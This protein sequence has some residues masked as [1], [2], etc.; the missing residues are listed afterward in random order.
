VFEAGA[1][2]FVSLPE[3]SDNVLFA[4]QKALARKRGAAVASGIASAPMIVIVGPKGG[5]GKTLTAVNLA[6]AL[7]AK[8]KRVAVVDLDLQFGDV[9][10]SYGLPPEKTIYDLAKSGGSLDTEKI[11][12]YLMKHRTGV[13]V[14][15]A[16]T[17]P[18]QASVVSIEFLREVYATLR[19]SNDF[20]I[21]DTPPGFTPEV[22]ATIDASSHV[23]MVAMLDALSL[24]N[25]KVGLETLELMGY[26][27]DRI[28]VVL[29]RADSRVGIT[30]TEV[31]DILG[32]VPDI[33]VPSSRNVPRAVNEGS[34][35][36]VADPKSAAARAFRSL[37][38][39]YIGDSRA[40][41]GE[42]GGP[43]RRRLSLRRSRS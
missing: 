12:A 25:T 19:S 36:T 6:A 29:N 8:Q 9:G 28:R 4:L 16:P 13:S 32:R 3:S 18:D 11:D 21:I 42:N 23:C 35:I 24:K 26:A 34:P 20:L 27:S 37:A 41:F 10:L 31:W 22:I 39:Q 5:T 2:D 7:A 33:S 30:D 40:E 17:R 43:K 1:D 14:L 38:E 15:T